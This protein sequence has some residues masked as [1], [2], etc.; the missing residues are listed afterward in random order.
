VQ[1]YTPNTV[2]TS[3]ASS[4]STYYIQVRSHR[5][6]TALRDGQLSYLARKLTRRQVVHGTR[7]G[8]DETALKT[9]RT[10]TKLADR[11]FSVAAPV[12]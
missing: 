1:T 6:Y 12:V 7:S 4:A 8:V 11:R 5:L 3:L 10:K 2:E 9:Q